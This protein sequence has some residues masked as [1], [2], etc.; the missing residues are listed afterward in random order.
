MENCCNSLQL[1]SLF[2][3]PL[4]SSSLFLLMAS[5][6]MVTLSFSFHSY[7]VFNFLGIHETNQILLQ[8]IEK[9]L[10]QTKHLKTTELKAVWIMMLLSLLAILNYCLIIASVGQHCFHLSVCLGRCL[11]SYFSQLIVNSN[12]CFGLLLSCVIIPA[13]LWANEIIISWPK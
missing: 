2:C 10:A 1:N 9:F 4:P 12:R 8:W 11:H 3:L 5:T 13:L 7:C 6:F